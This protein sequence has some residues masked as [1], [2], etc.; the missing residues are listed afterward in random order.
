LTTNGD[1]PDIDLAL[2]N[3][4]TSIRFDAQGNLWGTSR[5]GNA[6]VKYAAADLVLRTSGSINPTATF[7]ETAGGGLL[8]LVFDKDANLWTTGNNGHG[9][10]RYD[11]ADISALTSTPTA[12]T[13]KFKSTVPTATAVVLDAAGNL[14]SMFN[15]GGGYASPGRYDASQLAGTGSISDS[16]A[17]LMTP[18]IQFYADLLLTPAGQLVIVNG[19]AYRY[20]PTQIAQTGAVA[21]TPEATI[22]LSGITNFSPRWVSLDPDGNMWLAADRDRVVRLDASALAQTGAVSLAPGMTL[23][24]PVTNS[25]AVFSG[26]AIH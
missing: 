17:L 18:G 6:V 13:P 1:P 2:G 20:S 10:Y 25:S 15:P 19:S 3:P 24:A 14:Y 22:S 7:T 16:P 11:A 9:I 8:Y 26:L 5:S 23:R 12:L 21:T 4:L